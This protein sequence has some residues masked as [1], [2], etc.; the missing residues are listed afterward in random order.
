MKRIFVLVACLAVAFTSCE[1]EES[2]SEPES[3]LVY[4]IDNPS[5]AFLNATSI[6]ETEDATSVVIYSVDYPSPAFVEAQQLRGSRE[7][8][9]GVSNGTYWEVYW[10]EIGYVYCSGIPWTCGSISEAQAIGH[11]RATED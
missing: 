4:S 2:F 8:C 1:K 9:N 7:N 5:P 3:S 11:C 6:S 10:S